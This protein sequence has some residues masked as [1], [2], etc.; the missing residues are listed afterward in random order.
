MVSINTSTSFLETNK[1]GDSSSDTDLSGLENIFAS[2]LTL[3]EEEKL[4]QYIRK[5]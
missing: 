4:L 1:P 5:H 3:I 2:M